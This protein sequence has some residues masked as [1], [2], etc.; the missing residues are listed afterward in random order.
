MLQRTRAT[1]VVYVRRLRG[2]CAAHAIRAAHAL[3]AELFANIFPAR[4]LSIQIAPPVSPARRAS[5][6]SR[7]RSAT[8]SC[9]ARQGVCAPSRAWGSRMRAR[10]ARGI[11]G[12]DALRRT[13]AWIGRARRAARRAAQGAAHGAERAEERGGAQ[14]DGGSFW[15]GVRLG[16]MKMKH[17]TC[18][19]IPR[20]L[21]GRGLFAS[22]FARFALATRF[23]R[24]GT[25]RRSRGR[26]R[27]FAHTLPTV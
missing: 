21:I 14:S 27:W 26:R 5:A 20:A 9:A 17:A 2:R 4:F 6:A 19:M 15:D 24:A 11:A 18:T 10:I 7:A 25:P 23:S 12:G 8:V 22:K 3:G 1:H 13:R 16:G